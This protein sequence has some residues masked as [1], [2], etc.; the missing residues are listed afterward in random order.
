[1]ARRSRR[2]YV[3][4]KPKEQIT[5]RLTA[6]P[7][8]RH[9]TARVIVIGAS[10]GGT[11]AITEVLTAL[12]RTTPGTLIVRHMPEEFTTAFARRL[13]EQCEMQVR[14]A[15]HGDL[16]TSGLALIAPGNRHLTVA[17]KGARYVAQ[18][19]DGPPVHY[20]RPAVDVLFQA[21]ARHCGPNCVAAL[22][23]G[24]GQDGAQGLLA[25]RQAGAHTIAQDEQ[26]CVVYGMPRAAVEL[27]AVDE[28]RPLDEIAQ[29]LLTAFADDVK[30]QAS[31]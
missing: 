18:L 14:E 1:M 17:R 10:T 30:Q 20:Q 22:L 21:V 31:G 19:R 6:T 4:E 13:D 8:L 27:N 3:K 2:A 7:A 24:M 11:R 12:P 5:R 16:L 26:S 25:L 23:T 28:V 9:T 15:R 29:A